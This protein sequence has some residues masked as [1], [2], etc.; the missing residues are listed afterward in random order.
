MVT[1]VAESHHINAAPALGENFDAA[2]SPTVPAP[3][4]SQN[5]LRDK[6][7]QKLSHDFFV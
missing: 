4:P 1:S 3:A 6:S 2:L 7:Q 5:F